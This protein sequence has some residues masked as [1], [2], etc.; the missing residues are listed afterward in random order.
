MVQTPYK[1]AVYC[2]TCLVNGKKYVGKSIKGMIKRRHGHQSDALKFN[3]TRFQKA[4]RKYGTEMWVWEELFLSD[5][6]DT[7]KAVEKKFIS[8]F[9]QQG[10]ELYNLTEGGDGVSGFRM[11]E[12][13]RE[14]LRRAKLGTT[15]SEETKLKLR[16]A[17]LGT[18]L[19]PEV[20]AKAAAANRGKK[21][22][23]EIIEK[24]RSRVYSA[25]SIEKFRA[26]QN[27]R[28]SNPEEREK[29]RLLA[30]GR[31]ISQETREKKR[32]AMLGRT[33]S[34]ES[35]ARMSAAQKGRV[36]SQS[37]RDN[38]SAT[39]RAQ[40]AA[41]L[42]AKFGESSQELIDYLARGRPKPRPIRR[43]H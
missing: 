39:K 3:R 8:E 41:K 12:E 7:L 32:Q 25:E 31:E 27:K 11:T 4:L 28:F 35:L 16:K 29:Y 23:A 30:T 20:V 17:R 19:P 24:L 43:E 1:G 10:L 5:C 9:K 18:K 14:K 38:I 36:V 2:A 22:S 37:H 6:D 40:H 26:G 21:R 15:A 13:H 42:S 33:F 34:A